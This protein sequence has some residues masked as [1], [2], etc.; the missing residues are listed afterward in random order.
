MSFINEKDCHNTLLVEVCVWFHSH[1]RFLPQNKKHSALYFFSCF[2]LH[3][4]T[5]SVTQI[6]SLSIPFTI[7]H[8]NGFHSPETMKHTG[9]FHYPPLSITSHDS[10]LQLR[11]KPKTPK[12]TT[13]FKKF[14][15]SSNGKRSRPETPLLK[16][17]IHDKI[18]DSIEEKE[19]PSS[20]VKLSRRTGRNVKKQTELG[21]SARRLAAGLWRLQQPEVV[22]GGSQKWSGFQVKFKPFWK[23]M[24]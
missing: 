23:K 14:K 20:P 3:H 9:K 5:N 4:F 16:W 21:F 22:V 2:V 13:R 19:K 10:D 1:R 11:P 15:S 18:N 6:L 8:L 12:T 17:K 7:H 24:K